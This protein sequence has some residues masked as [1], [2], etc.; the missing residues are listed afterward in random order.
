VPA[1][2]IGA[3]QL[4]S[5]GFFDLHREGIP[6][7]GIDLD[8][9]PLSSGGAVVFR[10]D[11][12]ASGI[13][14]RALVMEGPND[15]SSYTLSLFDLASGPGKRTWGDLLQAVQGIHAEWRKELDSHFLLALKEEL[16]WPIWPI[17]G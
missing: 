16:F 2:H 12:I 8:L 3:P 9:L 6:P 13:P 1:G 4:A 14:E 15:T 17:K 7:F 10:A 11:N 5:L